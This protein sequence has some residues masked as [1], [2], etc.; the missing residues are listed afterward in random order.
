MSKIEDMD[1]DELIQNIIREWKEKYPYLSDVSPDPEL[2]KVI[3]AEEFIL[4][5]EK[6]SSLNDYFYP[7]ILNL[8][9]KEDLNNLSKSLLKLREYFNQSYYGLNKEQLN[10]VKIILDEIYSQLSKNPNVITV[11]SIIKDLKNSLHEV[12]D[13]EI[14]KFHKEGK[15]LRTEITIGVISESFIKSKDIFSKRIKNQ[16][17]MFY[18]LLVIISLISIFINGVIKIPYLIEKIKDLG[19]ALPFSQSNLIEDIFIKVSIILPTIWAVLFISKRINEDKKL[20]QAYLHKQ[21]VAQSFVT[22]LKFIKENNIQDADPETLKTLNRVMIESLG[23]N[24]ALL[25]DKSTSEKIPMEELLSKILD[26]TIAD[27]KS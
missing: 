26:R 3:D 4:V 8:L 13:K 16:T 10:N 5:K 11:T 20:E 25:L 23:L 24:P 17:C 22:Y 19:L 12:I 2:G 1:K 7:A 14:E 21:T 9:E 6:S 15:S 18:I 27:K